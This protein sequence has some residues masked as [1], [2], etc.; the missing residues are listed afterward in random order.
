MPRAHF[1]VDRLEGTHAIL[2]G[3]DLR[4]WEVERARLPTGICEGTVLS[5]E[6]GPEEPQWEGARVDEEERERRLRNA[7]ERLHRLRGSDP[8][9]DIS[10]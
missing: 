3:D 5:A 6:V 10:L 9:G 2:I 8:G 7:G 4:A 1:A